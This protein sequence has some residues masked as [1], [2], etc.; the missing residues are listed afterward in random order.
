MGRAVTGRINPAVV[1]FLAGRQPK[2]RLRLIDARSPI[3]STYLGTTLPI[4][5]VQ[6]VRYER[7]VNTN[8]RGLWQVSVGVV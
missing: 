5:R 7:F 2:E 3:A 1:S 8:P 4:S 6:Y